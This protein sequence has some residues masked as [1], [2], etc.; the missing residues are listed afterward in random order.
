[1]GGRI[2][3]HFFYIYIRSPDNVVGLSHKILFF[4]SL[5][6]LYFLSLKKGLKTK[7]LYILL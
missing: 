5:N 4:Q 1:M 7:K 2:L 3:Y 6:T